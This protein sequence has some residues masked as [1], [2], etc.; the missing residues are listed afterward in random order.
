MA[1]LYGTQMT[2]LNASQTPA[3]GFVHGS[4]RC[5]HEKITLASQA[6]ADI[7]Y[8]ARLPKGAVFLYGMLDT[9]TSLGSTTIQIGISGSTAKYKADATFTSTNTPTPFGKA[10]VQVALSAE[11]DVFITWSTATAPSSGTLN[12]TI[13]YAFD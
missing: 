9:D 2:K 8:I 13:F 5:F 1:T 6:A 3:P 11:E 10:G 4:V 7:T 12:V